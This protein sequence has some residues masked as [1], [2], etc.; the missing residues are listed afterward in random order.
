MS[1]DFDVYLR[2]KR[3]D[4]FQFS[5]AQDVKWVWLEEGEKREKTYAIAEVLD[6]SDS[7]NVRVRVKETAVEVTTHADK[8]FGFNPAKFDGVGDCAMLGYLSQ[9]A[10]LH[11]LKLRYDANCIYTHSGLFTVA[12][13]PYKMFPIY[14]PE[15]IGRYVNRR[16]NEVPP[17]VYSTADEAYRKVLADKK[18]QSMLVTG[19][20]GAGKTE[21]TKRIIQYLAHVAGRSGAEGKLE[22]QLLQAN[23]LLEALGNAK[24]LKNNNSSRFGKFIKITFEH[25]G[26]LSGASIV[27]YLLETSRVVHQGKDERSFHIFYQLFKLDDSI[28]KELKLKTPNDYRYLS[29]SGCTQVPG[30]NDEKEAKDTA[31]A[32]NVLGFSP[33]DQK[34]IYRVCAGLLHLGNT[35]FEGDEVATVV[36]DTPLNIAAELL[37][38]DPA[39]LK[40]GLISPSMMVAGSKVVKGTTPFKA[41]RSRDALVKMIYNRLFLWV[42]DKINA[43]L[44]VHNEHNFI[45]IL[46]IAGFEI[47]ELNSFEQLCINFTNERLQQFFNNHMFTLEQEEY[48]REKIDWTFIDFGVDSQATIDLISKKPR[49]V[50]F[51]L[52]EE[53]VF[54]RATDATFTQK[55]VKTYG[56]RHPKFKTESLGSDLAFGVEHYAGLVEYNSAQWLEKNKDPLEVDLRICIARSTAPTLAALWQKYDKSKSDKRNKG[57]SFMTVGFKYREQLDS[58]LKTLNA[59]YPHFVRCIIPNHRQI[60]GEI[61]DAIVLDQ[62]ACNG[63]LEGI[64]ISRMGFP[65]RQKYEDFLKRYYLL[66]DSVSKKSPNPKSATQKIIKKLVADK[67]VDMDKIRYGVTKIFF[68]AGEMAK[69]EEKREAIVGEMIREIQALGRGYVARKFYSNIK[70]RALAAALIGRNIRLWN[71]MK[72]DYWWRMITKMRNPVFKKYAAR[73]EVARE[74][75]K[76]IQVVVDAINAVE[77]DK[78]A[79][80]EKLADLQSQ[81]AAIEAELAAQ[82]D[83]RLLRNSDLQA[84]HDEIAELSLEVEASEEMLKDLESDWR[85]KNV[86]LAAVESIIRETDTSIATNS[87]AMSKL[88]S[89]IKKSRAEITRLTE[90]LSGEQREAIATQTAMDELDHQLDM[91]REDMEIRLAKKTTLT[92]E[93]SKMQ[94]E[95]TVLEASKTKAKNDNAAITKKNSA[96]TSETKSVQSKLNDAVKVHKEADDLTKKL[97]ATISSLEI[98]LESQAAQVVSKKEQNKSMESE[99]LDKDA[100]VEKL[101]R[102]NKKLQTQ[103]SLELSSLEEAETL[104]ADLEGETAVLTKKNSKNTS[105]SEK[106]EKELTIALAKIDSLTKEIAS[107]A[108]KVDEEKEANETLNKQNEALSNSIKKL[109]DSLKQLKESKSALVDKLSARNSAKS[110]LQ[111]NLSSLKSKLDAVKAKKS[112]AGNATTV[113][114]TNIQQVSAQLET[115][116]NQH[117]LAQKTVKSS[118]DRISELEAELKNAI[119]DSSEANK[120]VKNAKIRRDDIRERLELLGDEKDAKSSALKKKTESLQERNK[121]LANLV[122]ERKA[123]ETKQKELTTSIAT[124]TAQFEAVSK[125]NLAAERKLKSLEVDAKTLQEKVT[126]L[127]SEIVDAKKEGAALTLSI[128]EAQLDNENKALALD[129]LTELTKKAD[130]EQSELQAKLDTVAQQNKELT[131]SLRTLQEKS[132]QLASDAALQLVAKKNLQ[133]RLNDMEMEKEDILEAKDKAEKQKIYDERIGG[134]RKE[135]T[136][137]ELDLD[138]LKKARLADERVVLDQRAEVDRVRRAN[139]VIHADLALAEQDRRVVASRY[140]QV[141]RDLL[142]QE[143]VNTL[144]AQRLASVEKK[145]EKARAKLAKA[146]TQNTKEN[147][148]LAQDAEAKSLRDAAAEIRR[149]KNEIKTFA[150]STTHTLQSVRSAE[151]EIVYLKNSIR[152]LEGANSNLRRYEDMLTNEV[153]MQKGSIESAGETL[154]TVRDLTTQKDTIFAEVKAQKAETVVQR[155]LAQARVNELKRELSLIEEDIKIENEATEKARS[156]AIRLNTLVS[157]KAEGKDVENPLAQQDDETPLSIRRQTARALKAIGKLKERFNRAIVSKD[158]QDKITWRLQDEHQLLKTQLSDAYQLRTQAEAVV[159]SM[160]KQVLALREDAHESESAAEKARVRAQEGARDIELLKDKVMELEDLSSNLMHYK[161]KHKRTQVDLE[162]EL[163]IV[164][165]RRTESNSER[166]AL[167]FAVRSSKRLLSDERNARAEEDA[168]AAKIDS[169]LKRARNDLHISRAHLETLERESKDLAETLKITTK[170]LTQLQRRLAVEGEST[171]LESQ[172]EVIRH[173]LDATRKRTAQTRVEIRGKDEEAQ[174]LLFDQKTIRYELNQVK[175]RMKR[176]ARANAQIEEILAARKR[177]EDEDEFEDLD[178]FLAGGVAAY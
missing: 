144:E 77:G 8:V 158:A 169:N 16:R 7:N 137:V 6:D 18:S 151:A 65:N 1:T 174:A 177:A 43:T 10:V 47:F 21:N 51:I 105:K 61:D 132:D 170:Q 111:S 143:G 2:Y 80:K 50:L 159:E 166:L 25:S 94:T 141:N 75:R 120:K 129:R 95:L 168:K 83:E 35:D 116:K 100:E 38:V 102:D 31:F 142:E 76:K 146:A 13:N 171:R 29:I 108:Q 82:S 133:N 64:R 48:R 103:I 173:E 150:H 110:K 131:H 145:L 78:V 112:G 58:L 11:N 79:L 175:L 62:L 149:T 121:A 124:Q 109:Q 140:Q 90:N 9:P 89:A 71:D 27:S 4:S 113:I 117:R 154:A 160:H 138:A 114:K 104:L 135:K 60:P 45:G 139:K 134:L 66:D 156:L 30:I 106:L 125:Q 46:D 147:K 70:A 163:E 99:A 41:G 115:E 22:Q 15:V 128:K 148:I 20:S 40:E 127:E 24:T 165:A 5:L 93:N 57:A 161:I 52:D 53:C 14:T 118:Q 162:A 23:P 87:L 96:L 123:R 36:D 101:Q 74:W 12:V 68:R 107:L 172:I 85:S 3:P 97:T 39:T 81:Q 98:E 42:V 28:K 119:H 130:G 56:G 72:D 49:G 176:M 26:F 167:E 54:P 55:L 84:K 126:F 91:L 155:E 69:V 67:V 33:E 73:E 86:E 63:V 88:E 92:V 17:H 34:L 19:E 37:S 153:A 122:D 157:S 152:D 59:T 136:E 178:E 44:K 32:M 164:T